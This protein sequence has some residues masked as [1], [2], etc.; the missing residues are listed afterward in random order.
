MRESLEEGDW[1]EV[2]TVEGRSGC[3]TNILSGFAESY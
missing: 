1:H 3:S 2:W